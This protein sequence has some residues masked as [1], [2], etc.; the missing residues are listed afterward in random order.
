MIEAWES[1]GAKLK[2]ADPRALPAFF[3]T[4][5]VPII[6][7]N[8]IFDA[9]Y[10]PAV[11]RTVSKRPYLTQKG[12]VGLGHEGMRIGDSVCILQGGPVPFLLRKTERREN[13]L[14]S[15]T[16]VHGIMDGEFMETNPALELFD[17]SDMG[18]NM[19]SRYWRRLQ[20]VSVHEPMD[21]SRRNN[22]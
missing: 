11:D 6:Q 15:D 1:L 13:V 18:R 10:S 4:N 19:G 2:D 17:S 16:Y 8:L 9:L 22:L 7:R 3:D 20:A 14:V 21:G 12:Y 5:V